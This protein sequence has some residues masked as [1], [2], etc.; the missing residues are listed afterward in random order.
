MYR[1][2]LTL[3][4]LWKSGKITVT[5]YSYRNTWNRQKKYRIGNFGVEGTAVQKKSK[6]R[7][8]RKNAMR[9]V[10]NIKPVLLL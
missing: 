9:A 5:R 7:I 3:E 2:E 4:L 8:Q 6:S 10:R 1:D